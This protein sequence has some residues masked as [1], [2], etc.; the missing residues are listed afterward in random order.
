MKSP[1]N[2]F[3]SQEF[4]QFQLQVKVAT[5]I[6]YETETQVNLIN[7]DHL[8]L[9]GSSMTICARNSLRWRL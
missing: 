6:I 5:T 4:I 9:I 3:S 2:K 8:L 1:D 7:L